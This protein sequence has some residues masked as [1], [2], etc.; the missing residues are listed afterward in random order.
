MGTMMT[1]EGR[2]VLM[3]DVDEGLLAFLNGD[4]SRS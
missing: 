3:D 1:I 4:E 2:R